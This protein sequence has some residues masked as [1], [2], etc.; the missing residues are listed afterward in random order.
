MEN[1]W[2]TPRE[3]Q[4]W[5]EGLIQRQLFYQFKANYK[6]LSEEGKLQKDVCEYLI[7][8]HDNQQQTK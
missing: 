2:N 4:K 7:A 3:L 5:Y 8:G 6:R 1:L